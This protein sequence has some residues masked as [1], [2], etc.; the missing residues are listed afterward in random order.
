MEGLCNTAHSECHL[1]CFSRNI[2]QT[3]VFLPLQLKVPN[4][5]KGWNQDHG[6][7]FGRRP[8]CKQ[9]PV[10]LLHAEKLEKVVLLNVLK[11]WFS[12]SIKLINTIISHKSVQCYL[13]EC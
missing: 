9:I 5:H 3:C 8:I 2:L 4:L 12:A 6:L 7:L 10:S 1:K 11:I 13:K